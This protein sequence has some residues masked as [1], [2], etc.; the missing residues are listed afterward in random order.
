MVP[1]GIHFRALNAPR[2]GP[3]EGHEGRRNTGWTIL[4]ITTSPPPCGPAFQLLRTRIRTNAEGFIRARTN[5]VGMRMRPQGPQ[6]AV[7]LWLIE[8][9]K[10][11]DLF[12][13]LA[14]NPWVYRP[15]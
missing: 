14:H 2:D 7:P 12:L 1:I 15:N 3:G 6:I 10:S 9:S 5:D 13:S 11:R 4:R 8:W